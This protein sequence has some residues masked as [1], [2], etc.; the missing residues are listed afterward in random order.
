MV[1]VTGSGSGSSSSVTRLSVSVSRGLRRRHVGRC[2]GGDIARNVQ[3]SV[4]ADERLVG[5]YGEN[6]AQSQRHL[7]DGLS[8]VLD[9]DA[10][11]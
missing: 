7:A 8:G 5:R 10:A 9:G 2:T 11:R 1:N 6:R 4:L 3:F